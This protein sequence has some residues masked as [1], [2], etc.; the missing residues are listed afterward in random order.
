MKSNNRIRPMPLAFQVVTAFGLCLAW[1]GLVHAG[2]GDDLCAGCHEE[3][4]TAFAAT[5][6][7]TYLSGQTAAGGTCQS[8]HGAGEK[9][10]DSGDPKDILNP[11]GLDQFAAGDPCLACHS[12]AEFD[13]WAV[14]Q[15]RTGDVRC[16][17]CHKVHQ[18]A[19][20]SADRQSPQLCYSCHADM[21]AAALMPSHHPIAEGKIACIDCH[22]PHGGS[23]RLTQENTGRE[24]CFSCH[25]DKEGPFVYEH[26]PVSE[27]CMVCH[28]PH[29]SVADNLLKQSEPTLCLSCHAMH[30]HSTAEGVDGPFTVPLNTTRN[31]V[32]TSNGWKLGMLTKC[33]QCHNAIHGTDMP[34]QT[35][36]TGGNALTR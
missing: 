26:A 1:A 15:H 4:V 11:V 23:A 2:A 14:S 27:D 33:T 17:S 20:T 6:H 13:D 18:P 36:S 5:T 16:A 7:G 19:S 3:I 10:A 8:C 35:I 28:Q 21:K 31:G 9:H 25:A 32:S 34:S 30:F 29:G 24:L 12:G 22:N